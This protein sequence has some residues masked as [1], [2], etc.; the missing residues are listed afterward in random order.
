MKHLSPPCAPL[1]LAVL[2][3]LDF[4]ATSLLAE[5]VYLTTGGTGCPTCC[6]YD[7]GTGTHSPFLSAACANVRTYSLFGITNTAMWP[8]KPTLARSN[9]TY[10]ILVTKGRADDCSTNIIVNMTAT[11]GTLTDADGIPQTVVPT[12][13]FQK[14]NSVD[15]WTLVGCINNITN[16][17]EV[18]FAYAS[19]TMSG[20]SR[21]YMDAVYFRSV[22]TNTNPATP[23]RI[24][25]ILCGNPLTIAGTGPVGHPFALVSSTNPAKALNLWTPEQTNTAGNGAF[26]FDVPPGTAKAGFFRVITQ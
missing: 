13:A 14:S 16:K 25:Q 2:A 20:V 9:G 17:P 18:I 4:G 5:D 26:F 24:T 23:A 12:T 19:G 8:I 6:P 11:G 21:W 1:L 7:L 3:L 10:Q 15:C 22:D